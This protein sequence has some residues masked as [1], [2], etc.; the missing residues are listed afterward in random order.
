MK[1]SSVIMNNANW[2]WFLVATDGITVIA[3]AVFLF[4]YKKQYANRNI[5]TFIVLSIVFPLL[6]NILMISGLRNQFILDLPFVPIFG[7][8]VLSPYLRSRRRTPSEMP[9][10]SGQ[11][12][13]LKILWICAA[14]A[15]IIPS[16][17][18]LIA[19]AVH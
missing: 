14:I 2:Q 1:G 10:A 12:T 9:L 15:F 17:F 7:A 18:L 8:S 16:I 11:R 5:L 13:G 19:I 4:L 6:T 3:I